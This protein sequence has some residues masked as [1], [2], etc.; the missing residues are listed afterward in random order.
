MIE[1]EREDLWQS[2][3]PCN[4][5]TRLSHSFKLNLDETSFLCN[6]V[7][8]NVIWNDERTHDEKYCSDLR[9]SITALW[10]WIAVGV[11]RPV[12]LLGIGIWYTLGLG[13][14]TWS[15]ATYFQNDILLLQTNQH[16]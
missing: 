14:P 4:I 1:A 3:S 13:V 11:N 16:T 12:I 5:F 2:N 8:L 9:F 10:I 6:E 15:L 7:E